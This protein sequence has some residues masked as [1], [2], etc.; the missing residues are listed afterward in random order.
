ML[1]IGS[2]VIATV[3][4]TETLA[5]ASTREAVLTDPTML[6]KD[7]I[8]FT[9][10]DEYRSSRYCTRKNTEFNPHYEQIN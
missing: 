4:F 1:K 2:V 10:T 9:S 3:L 6:L 8:N 5:V 7:P